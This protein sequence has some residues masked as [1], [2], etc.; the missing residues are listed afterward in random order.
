MQIIFCVI[1]FVGILYF[2]LAKR[3]FDWFTVAYFSACIYFLPGFIGYTSYLTLTRWSETP[4]N[5][6]AYCI[7]I[8]VEI[9]ILLGAIISD[10][11]V[12][13]KTVNSAPENCTMLYTT[14]FISILALV[15]MF[16]TTGNAIFYSDKQA[17]MNELNRY[18]ILYYTATMIGCIMSF[19]YKKWLL[20]VIF[21]LLIMFDVF[22]GFRTTCAISFIGI[23]TLWLAKKGQKRFL[24]HYWKQG[25][26]GASMG[27]LLFLYKQISYAV[28]IGDVDLLM[29]LFRGTSDTSIFRAM[30]INSEPFITQ[31]VLNAV[32]QSHYSV[33][34]HHLK[35]LFY[36]FILFAPQFGINAVSFNDLYQKDLFPDVEYGMANNIWAEMWSAGGWPLLMLFLLTF[37]IIVYIATL[38]TKVQNP[39]LRSVV[40][41]MASY[42]AF[43]IHRN[44]IA[45]EMN[46]EKRV[47]LVV[48][49]V[50][51]VSAF[52]RWVIT[53]R[54]IC[55]ST[56]TDDTLNV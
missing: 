6:E 56:L 40:A 42:W 24:F 21:C 43:Y 32:T 53:T 15:L 5:N 49:L 27:V 41:V 34:L 44:D 50:F 52:I 20:L 8:S 51:A 29:S 46:L 22:I 30:F 11:F 47:L 13:E 35:G 18:Y 4:I 28:K 12:V 2:L 31:T 36:Q 38:F 14:L 33:G 9:M 25:I 1:S 48:G 10:I 17:M 23:I 3:V 19:E 54:P 45:Y 55:S 7:M 26:I 37:V 16:I 39:S